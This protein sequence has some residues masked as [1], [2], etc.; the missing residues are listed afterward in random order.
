MYYNLENVS[1]FSHID[2]CNY[3]DN[4]IPLKR[5]VSNKTDGGLSVLREWITI[6]LE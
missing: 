2:I 4:P 6:C 1:T 5:T 3:T